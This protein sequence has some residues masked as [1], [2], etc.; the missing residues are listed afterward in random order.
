MFRMRNAGKV[1][2]V[3]TSQANGELKVKLYVLILLTDVIIYSSSTVVVVS[4][5]LH[6][7]HQPNVHLHVTSNRRL[8]T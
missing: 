8:A 5:N 3:N 1:A 7:H 2:D 4:S 6:E